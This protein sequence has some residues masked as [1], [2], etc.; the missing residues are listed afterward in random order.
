MFP[1]RTWIF[2]KWHRMP[3][4]NIEPTDFYPAYIQTYIE[5]DVRLLKNISDLSS[6]HKFIKL[7]AGRCS[8]IFNITSLADDAGINRKTAAAWLSVLEKSYIIYF[9]KPY[10]M[11]RPRTLRTNKK[12]LTAPNFTTIRLVAE[13]D[14][15]YHT[16]KI[17]GKKFYG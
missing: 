14:K 3:L 15:C 13:K 2:A 5:K 17:F 10:F 6:F 4:K 7:C 9:L 12:V 11:A 8:Q 16:M 1:L